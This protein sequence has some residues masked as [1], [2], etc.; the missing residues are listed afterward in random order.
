MCQNIIISSSLIFFRVG[1]FFFLFRA[2]PRLI[3]LWLVCLRIRVGVILRFKC[4]SWAFFSIVLLFTGGMIVLFSYILTLISSSKIRFPR[5][6]R[7]ILILTAWLGV[8][9]NFETYLRSRRHLRDL[10]NL[11]FNAMLYFLAVYLF[12]VLV[13]VVKLSMRFI[14]PLKI[15]CSHEI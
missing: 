14:G 5:E 4:S 8:R 9:V 3:I 11:G 12:L 13:V 7:L 1:V 2:N 10:Y 15:L 6:P